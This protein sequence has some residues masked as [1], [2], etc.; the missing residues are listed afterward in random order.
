[1]TDARYAHL[2]K[3]RAGER[4]GTRGQLPSNEWRVALRSIHPTN[5]RLWKI[6]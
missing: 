3:R 4:T 2:S 5:C 1:M 6:A